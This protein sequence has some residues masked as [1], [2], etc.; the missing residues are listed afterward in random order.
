M[1]IRPTA[2]R[3]RKKEVTPLDRAIKYYTILSCINDLKLRTMEI[4]LVAFTAIKGNLSYPSHRQEFLALYDTSMGAIYNMIPK[5][6]RMG[7][8]VKE[9]EKTKVNP[10]ILLDFN[11]DISLLIN[12]VNG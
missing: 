4:R 8:L 3:I 1:E 12:I 5:L 11:Q 10:R 7:L 9:A 2:Q 6:K